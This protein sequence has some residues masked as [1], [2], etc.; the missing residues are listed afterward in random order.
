[1]LKII[2]EDNYLKVIFD[3][4]PFVLKQKILDYSDDMRVK[5]ILDDNGY[6]DIK[7]LLSIYLML[8]KEPKE[9][10]I[11]IMINSIIL[12]PKKEG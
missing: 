12:I 5:I 1:M 2:S 6:I 11:H 9:S 8:E 10:E 4:L 7:N 3:H